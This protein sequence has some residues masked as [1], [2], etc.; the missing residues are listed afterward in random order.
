MT[1]GPLAYLDSFGGLVPCR[2][3]ETRFDGIGIPWRFRVTYTATRGAYKR[4]E[5]EDWPAHRIV[6]RAAI[7]RR[8]GALII[9]PYI[10]REIAP[11]LFNDIQWKESR[12]D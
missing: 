3:V 11:E 6:P 5:S 9:R 12:H 10:W 7:A 4:G 8:A 1:R 2:I